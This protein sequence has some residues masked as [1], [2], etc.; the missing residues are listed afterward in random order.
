MKQSIH[1]SDKVILAPMAGVSDLAFRQICRAMGADLAYSEMV[2][3]KALHFRDKKTL[4]L[5]R[6]DAEPRPHIVQIFGH[7]PEVLAEAAKYISEFADVIDINMGCPAPKI[8]SGGDGA[9]LMQNIPLPAKIVESVVRAA[10]VPVTVKIRKGW[11]RETAP[12]MAHALSESGA[13]AIAVHGRTAKEQYRGTA[14]WGVIRRVKAAVRVPVIGNGDIRCAA[15]A[16]RM[17]A[18]TGC[19][20]VMIG[21]G[22]MGN[23][24][25]FRQIRTL[26]VLGQPEPAPTARE[27]ASVFLSQLEH[28]IEYK[29]MRTAILEARKHAAWYVHGLPGAS[30]AREQIHRATTYEQ[31]EEILLSFAE[32]QEK[33][34][35]SCCD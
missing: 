34:Y 8:T 14:D 29:G 26:S 30:A 28:M 24:F 2:S 18:E 1:F 21:R 22:A 3:A 13:A 6:F 11:D 27:A 12:E 7:E 32:K 15:D 16:L 33:T 25:L 31:M 20:S 23:P 5:L 9:A 4:A 10:S 19:D 17:R 35:E